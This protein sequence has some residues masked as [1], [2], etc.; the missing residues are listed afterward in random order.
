VTENQKVARVL[1]Q[2]GP[3]GVGKT[4]V[5]AAFGLHLAEQGKRVLVMTIDPSKRLAQALGVSSLSGVK[6]VPTESGS[7][8]LYACI[9]DHGQIFDSFIKK[10]AFNNPAIEKLFNNRLYQSLKT[11]LQ[12]SQ[13]FTSLIELHNQAHSGQFDIVILD[14]PP[15]QH[16]WQFLESPEKL[17]ALFREKIMKWF[18]WIG[19]PE[20]GAGFWNRMISAGTQKVLGALEILTGPEFMKQISDFFKSIYASQEQ[21]RDKIERAEKLLKSDK[22]EFTL[23]TTQ[24]KLKIMESSLFAREILNRGYHLKRIILNRAWPQSE[25]GDL[26][27]FNE[28]EKLEIQ[29]TFDLF[30][31]QMQSENELISQLPKNI[32]ILRVF[33][34]MKSSHDLKILSEMANDM[35]ESI[36]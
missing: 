13:D 35:K 22:T 20:A 18:R 8:E 29:K 5:S 28:N 23:I 17:G 33:D 16:A 21:L 4:T 2:M 12:G 9:L 32:E 36:K 6:K 24:D 10:I 7:G 15:A 19:E 34:T 14:T 25:V 11:R 26:S 1:I 3:G 27:Q 30:S 31:S